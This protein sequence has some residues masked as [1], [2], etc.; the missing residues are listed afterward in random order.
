M[1]GFLLTSLQA[2]G[3]SGESLEAQVLF[4]PSLPLQALKRICLSRVS[5][6]GG[7]VLIR[8]VWSFASEAWGELALHTPISTGLTVAHGPTMGAIEPM[9][10]G[11][12]SRAQSARPARARRHSDE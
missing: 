6:S 1:E 5:S 4:R 7:L 11:G 8:F 12:A 9:G 10:A 2:H 3:A